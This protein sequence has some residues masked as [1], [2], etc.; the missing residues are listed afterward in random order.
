MTVTAGRKRNPRGAGD[1]LRAGL[2]DAT[3]ELL[4]EQGGPEGLSIRA[5]TERAG[6][7]PMALYLH[8]PG[9]EELLWAVCDAAFEELLVALH[10]AE[11]AHD[12]EPRE[13]LRAIGEAYMDFA[14]E[15]PSLYRIAFEMPAPRG[16]D[17]ELLPV[18]DPGMR[19]FEDLVRATERCLPEGGDA[20]G[21]ALQ[22]W[23]ALHGFISLRAI[24]PKF[25]W[26][27]APAFLSD[28][29]DAHL[30]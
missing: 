11:A 26:P 20:R 21:V 5:I 12:G 13:Q 4:L 19:A 15:R 8:F 6:V 25:A 3:V 28:L 18:D 16:G 14:L 30:G 1:R 7:S 29:L 24:V 23:V 9:K 22:L 2:M 27:E 17:P 10:E